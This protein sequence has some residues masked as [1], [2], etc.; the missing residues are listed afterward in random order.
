MIGF[1]LFSWGAIFGSFL[2]VCIHRLPRDQSIVTPRSHCP[3]CKTP[4]QWYDNVPIISYLVLR[5]K[6]RECHAPIS[7]RYVVTEI[8]SGCVWLFLWLHFD[9]S[10]WFIAGVTLFS[11]LLALSIIDFE[12]G[13]L[14]DVLTFPGMG[15]GLILSAAYPALQGRE[16]WFDGLISSGIGLVAGGAILLVTGVIGNLIFKKESMGGGDIK[17][18]AMIGA[19]LGWQGAL[20][21]FFLSPIAALPLALYERYVRKEETIPFGPFLALAGAGMYLFGDT[22]VNF[23]FPTIT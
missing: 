23:L 8:L 20:L 3:K 12:T 22:V 19:F 7:W 4:I 14:P 11:I 18:L 16:G 13:Y 6:C 21:V 1:L 15:L 10:G 5:G 9:F 2:N 17:L